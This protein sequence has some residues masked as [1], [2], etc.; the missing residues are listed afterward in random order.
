[1][2]DIVARIKRF[3]R[4]RE[5]PLLRRKYAEMRAGVF[6]FYRGTCHLFYEDWASHPPVDGAPLA[7][8]S[9]DLHPENF[10]SFRGGDGGVYFD[11]N[12]FDEAALGPCVWD[13]AR[14]ITGI[15]VGSADLGILDE[16]IASLARRYLYAYCSSLSSGVAQAVDADDASGMVRE[17]LATVR[18]RPAGA[19]VKLHSARATRA[20][21]ARAEL[22]IAHVNAGLRRRQ[23]YEVLDV[24]QR[25]AGTGSLG[26]PRFVVLAQRERTL[27]LLDCKAEP[28]SSLAPYLH[29]RQPR[30]KN[31]AERVV[32]IQSIAQVS[33]PSPLDAVAAGDTSFVVRELEPFDDRVRWTRWHGRLDR[34]EHLMSAMGEVTGWSHLRGASWRGAAKKKILKTFA[35]DREWPRAVA[36]YARAYAQQVGA[37]FERFAKAYDAG[38]FATA[39]G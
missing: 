31:D 17:L 8:V 9:G 27:H 20:E 12:D 35:H 37:D 28:V 22:L 11:V 34:L 16:D 3:N 26:V 2:A 15:W 33:R 4:G 23:R 14:C 32:G 7:W 21:T 30:W 10:G 38:R 24:A 29:A 36:E 5:A 39:A 6:G 18:V 25:I 1:V 19:L 13:V